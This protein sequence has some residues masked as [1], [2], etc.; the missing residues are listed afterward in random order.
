MVGT[1]A[2]TVSS[3]SVT[4][5]AQLNGA[6]ARPFNMKIQRELQGPKT[7]KMAQKSVKETRTGMRTFFSAHKKH[8]LMGDLNQYCPVC[9]SLPVSMR[10]SDDKITLSFLD[11]PAAVALGSCAHHNTGCLRPQAMKTQR[12]APRHTLPFHFRKQK[13]LMLT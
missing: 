5:C 8:A 4:I 9:D 3:P 11:L 12:F 13:L 7:N 10:G 1:C 6:L 2:Y